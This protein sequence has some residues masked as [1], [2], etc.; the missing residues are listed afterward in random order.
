MKEHTDHGC[1]SSSFRERGAV[2]RL[3]IL[4]SPRTTHWVSRSSFTDRVLPPEAFLM[5]R[6]QRVE[7]ISPAPKQG[8]PTTP[9]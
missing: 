9:T 6:F 3:Q 2:F 5:T 8:T 4:C 1:F 7:G